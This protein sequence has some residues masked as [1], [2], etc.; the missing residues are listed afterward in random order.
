[1]LLVLR[2]SPGHGYELLEQLQTLMPAER[3]DMGNLYR[4]LRSL[5][6]EG[7]VA[8]TWH[9]EAPGPAKRIYVITPSGR[10]VLGQWV[11]AFEED[12][13]ADRRLYR[14]L[15]RGEG[16]NMHHGH[17][18][19]RGRGRGVGHRFY[20]PE[21]VLERLEEYQRDLEQEIADVADLISKLKK[22]EPEAVT[23]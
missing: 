22:N 14:A 9:E 20:E 11:E 8:S 4:I 21:R 18:R 1:M 7:L 5:E 10:R 13:A 16:V 23:V 12:R 15:Q 2:D 17:R 6:R 3:I 19:F